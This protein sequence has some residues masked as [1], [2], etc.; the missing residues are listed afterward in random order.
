MG[1]LLQPINAGTQELHL[2][3]TW[4]LFQH[5]IGVDQKIFLDTWKKIF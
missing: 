5:S 3:I 4:K 1:S 2:P